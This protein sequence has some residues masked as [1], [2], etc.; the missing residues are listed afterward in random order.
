MTKSESSTTDVPVSNTESPSSDNGSNQAMKN[1]V[2]HY[3]SQPMPAKS[4]GKVL[5]VFAILLSIAALA[6]SAFT[7]YQTQMLGL[8]EESK[9][10]VGVSDIG[11]QVSRI[12]DTVARLKQD[13][14]GVVSEDQLEAKMTVLSTNLS[15]KM[16]EVADQQQAFNS[17]VE[18]ISQ[19]LEEGVGQYTLAEAEQLLKLANNSLIFAN[20][21]DS[22]SNALKLADSQLQKLSDP[23]LVNV[24]SQITQ[25]LTLLENTTKVDVTA[26]SSKLNT[27]AKLVPSL[28]LANEPDERVIENQSDEA[29]DV[30]QNSGVKGFFSEVWQDVL[31]HVSIQRIDQPP[32]P[33][34]APEQRY[35]LNQ[36]IQLSLAKAEYALMRQEA[37]IFKRGVGDATTWLRDYFDL[38]N[39]EVGSVLNQL[40]EIAAT[41]I[42]TTKPDISG[43]YRAL[44]NIVG[45]Q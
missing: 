9:L 12:G 26:I 34:L 2:E 29:V 15:N 36:N 1:A 11:A 17:S 18:K 20:D 23:R 32:K 5:S 4:G 44:Q 7:W 42:E 6:G 21:Y 35:F 37:E 39:P 24:R 8:Q 22:A 30:Q 40:D 3:P 25:E 19:R 14:Q 41:K 45:G 38:K 31:S 27:L 33:L 13:Q 10:A 28:P 43:S 16:K